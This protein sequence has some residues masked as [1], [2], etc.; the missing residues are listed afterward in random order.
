MISKDYYDA[1]I[2]KIILITISRC[3]TVILLTEFYHQDQI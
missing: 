2:F 1:L 3:Y